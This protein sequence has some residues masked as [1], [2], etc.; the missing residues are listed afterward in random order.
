MA[1]DAET[2]V[3]LMRMEAGLDTGP[4]AR[5]IRTPIRPDETAG[6]LAARLAEIGARAD[7]RGAARARRGSSR[8]SRAKRRG[9][10][11]CA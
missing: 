9:R 10:N 6:E 4:V 11:L 2:G 3:D 1:G 8:V 7:R 5:E